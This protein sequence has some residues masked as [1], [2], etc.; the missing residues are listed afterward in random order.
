MS[1]P[2]LAVGLGVR[3]GTDA[4]RIRA[5]LREVLGDN[6]IACLATIDRRAAE[7]G[8]HAAAQALGVPVRSYTAAEL[9]GV[10]VPNP[11]ARTASALGTASVAEASALLAGRGPLLIAKT[12]INGVVIAATAAR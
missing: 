9:A 4:D 10:R 6:V 3:P 12:T 2:D 5:A 1:R 8:L 11:S 7:P